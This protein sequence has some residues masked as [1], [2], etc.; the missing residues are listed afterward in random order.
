MNALKWLGAWFAKDVSRREWG[1][2]IPVSRQTNSGLAWS[3]SN[4]F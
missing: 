4:V 1:G 3:W 2:P